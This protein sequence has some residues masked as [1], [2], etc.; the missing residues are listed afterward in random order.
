MV[1]TISVYY[2]PLNTFLG[3]TYYHETYVYTNSAGQSYYTLA[4][5]D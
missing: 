2:E 5:R 3:T 1:E 4:A